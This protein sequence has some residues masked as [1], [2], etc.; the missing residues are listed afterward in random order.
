ME[1][2]ATNSIFF[3]LLTHC[4]SLKGDSDTH[5]K[6]PTVKTGPKTLIVDFGDIEISEYPYVWLRENCQCSQCFNKDAIARLYLMDDLDMD[7]HP[8]SLKVC[9]NYLIF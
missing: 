6:T 9:I 3:I 2:I 7:V 5:A 4:F 1:T 8:I